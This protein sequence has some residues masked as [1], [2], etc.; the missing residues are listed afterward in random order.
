[1]RH[2]SHPSRTAPRTISLSPS[3][4][5]SFSFS[6]A[7]IIIDRHHSHHRFRHCLTLAIDLAISTSLS[8]T[9]LPSL[10]IALAIVLII[11]HRSRHRSHQFALSFSPSLALLLIIHHPLVYHLEPSCAS[12]GTR[13]STH[14]V[15]YVVLRSR[16]GGGCGQASCGVERLLLAV[17]ILL[18]PLRGATI[19][20][21]ATPSNSS[22]SSLHLFT[23]IVALSDRPMIAPS[24]SHLCRILLVFRRRTRVN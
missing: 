17:M 11:R 22:N 3:L 1:M 4:S 12:P 20:R 2:R 21:C 15:Q 19:S 9:L 18:R 10:A 8:P 5:Q 16:G 6:L 13:S 24:S 7:R 23:A 14:S